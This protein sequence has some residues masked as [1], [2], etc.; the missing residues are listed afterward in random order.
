[1]SAIQLSDPKDFYIN[2]EGNILIKIFE[3]NEKTK[4]LLKKIFGLFGLLFFFIPLYYIVFVP[5]VLLLIEISYLKSRNIEK[6]K[7]YFKNLSNK[8]QKELLKLLSEYN[9]KLYDLS[10]IL[11][12]NK[13]RFVRTRLIYNRFLRIR[14]VFTETEQELSGLLSY[15]P[16]EVPDRTDKELSE[17]MRLHRENS[18]TAFV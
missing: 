16:Y 14:E 7:R 15:V 2:Y 13:S 1:M 6:H 4:S 12:N 18:K 17:M 8:E 3:I 9:K 5:L 10:K 11:R